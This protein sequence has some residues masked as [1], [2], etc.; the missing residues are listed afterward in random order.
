MRY[1]TSTS[2]NTGTPAACTRRTSG[3]LSGIP[4][5]STAT[6]RSRQ[7][8]RRARPARR[9]ARSRRELG[10]R[11]GELLGRCLVGRGDRADAR[12]STSTLARPLRP[13]PMTRTCSVRSKRPLVGCVHAVREIR[14]S[15][16]ARGA[17]EA[18]QKRA[19][20]LRLGHAAQFE[21]MVQRAHAEHAPPRRLVRRD[22][23][24]DAQ[25]F[26]N[27]HA[28]DEQQQQLRAGEDRDAG[29]RSAERERTGVAHEH[30]RRM[31][32]VDQETEHRAGR[33]RATA[34]T[35]NGAR[36][37]PGGARRARAAAARRSARQ[38]V[39]PVG[40]VD[41]V[42]RREDDAQRER[43]PQPRRHAPMPSSTVG[44]RSGDEQEHPPRRPR[45]ARTSGARATRD[46]SAGGSRE[47]VDG[48]DRHAGGRPAPRARASGA[49]ARTSSATSGA[50]PNSKPP[51]VGVPVFS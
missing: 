13:R 7:R 44:V 32:V 38:P 31:A 27:E 17:S 29:E 16:G 25:R 49:T 41:R 11:V 5:E 4:G 47:V 50:T 40:E 43:V 18:S 42:R 21:M 20:H 23:D 35:P 6:V 24:D 30:P 37:Q 26:G 9:T 14:A 48:A 19:R 46:S 10:E 15:P 51:I 8:R 33:R 12:R 34:A 36:E 1:A 22:L 2:L 45:S 39:Q 3:L 28:A